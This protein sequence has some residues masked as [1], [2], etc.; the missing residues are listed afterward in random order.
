[1]TFLILALAPMLAGLAAWLVALVT[2]A[3]LPLA[4]PGTPDHDSD[5][6]QAWADELSMSLDVDA[7]WGALH[8]VA[9][10]ADSVDHEW[11]MV[12]AVAMMADELAPID[13]EWTRLA[14]GPALVYS[15]PKPSRVAART[16]T[17]RRAYTAQRRLGRQRMWDGM[18]ERRAA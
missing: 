15:A 5:D 11:T 14:A 16:H 18:G 8:E 17:P 12:H 2:V 13:A 9:M 7:E 4:A 6:A 1:M 3:M 10:L